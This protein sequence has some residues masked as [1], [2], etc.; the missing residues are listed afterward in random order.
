MIM[1]EKELTKFMVLFVAYLALLILSDSLVGSSDNWLQL[2]PFAI[3]L[4]GIA[5]LIAI[6]PVVMILKI[7]CGLLLVLSILFSVFHDLFTGSVFML[8]FGIMFLI[9]PFLN[10]L[11]KKLSISK[12]RERDR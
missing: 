7:I 9:M 12:L 5:I 4:T 2:I 8:A 1:E 10:S 6:M 11:C 3:W